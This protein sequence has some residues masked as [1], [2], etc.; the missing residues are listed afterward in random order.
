MALCEYSWR[1]A[2]SGSPGS[3][4]PGACV[5]AAI[6]TNTDSKKVGFTAAVAVWAG[7]AARGLSQEPLPGG[8]HRR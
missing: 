1:I 7:G 2:A 5:L 3:S 6:S 8:R 4:P